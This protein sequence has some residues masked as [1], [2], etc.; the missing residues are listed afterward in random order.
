VSRARAALAAALLA[1]ALALP[2]RAQEPPPKPA[3]AAA[4]APATIPVAEVAVRVEELKPLLGEMEARTAPPAEVIAIQEGVA[5]EVEGVTA[6][7][8]ESLA[9][10]ADAPDLAW[11]EDLETGWRQAEKELVARDQ[12]LTRYLQ[13]I[14]AQLEQ[15]GALSDLWKNTNDVL[16]QAGAPAPILARVKEARAEI[17]ATRKRIEAQRDAALETQNQVAQLKVQS[18]EVLTRV[19]DARSRMLSTLLVR[20]Q[21]PLWSAWQ[22][23]EGEPPTAERLRAWFAQERA[24]VARWFQNRLPHL[25]TLLVLLAAVLAATL[26]L[27]RRALRWGEDDADLRQTA[28]IFERPVA[29]A[30][31]TWL[32]LTPVFHG[33]DPPIVRKLATLVLLVPLARALPPL[34]DGPVRTLFWIAMG[35]LVCDRARDLLSAA[36][37]LERAIF[38][39]ETAL[40]T[41]ALAW[42]GRPARLAQLALGER[43]RRWLGV[44]LRLALAALG[45]ALVANVLGYV[46]L[47]KLL[48]DGTLRSG[49]VLVTA[50]ALLR[51]LEGLI[52]LVLRLRPVRALRVVDHRR[53]RIASVALRGV[54]TALLVLWGV[55][56]LELFRLREPLFAAFGSLFGATLRVR[57]LEISLGGV[58]A[59][60]V[61]LAVSWGISRLLRA[62]LEEDVF[63]RFSTQRGVPYAVSTFVGYAVLTVGFL[64][65]L[66]AAGIDFGRVV[67]FA[68]ALGVG[69][70]L[71]LQDVVKNFVSGAILLFERP[72]QIG[73][74]VQLGDLL[75]VVQR[76]G[77]RSST[78]R[79]MDGAEVIIPNG[80]LVAEP[81]VNWTLSDRRRRITLPVGA[82]YGSDPERVIAILLEAAHAHPRVLAEP[83]PSAVFMGFGESACDFQLFAWTASFDDW[84]QT[85]S[86]L[87][88]A[89]GRALR[90]AG[91]EIPFPQREVHLRSAD[92]EAL[93][94]LARAARREG[95]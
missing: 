52:V 7:A 32:F 51:I 65:A 5:A 66:A 69:I 62:L 56:T 57:E 72:I 83:A 63:P 18:G 28:R 59:F 54:R 43:G 38:A 41:A 6:R 33:E 79:S 70:G 12:A 76:I 44:A 50:Y 75:G 60:G 53:G 49:Y 94:A 27:R 13:G 15:L 19:A 58:F 39:A 8:A 74:A 35:F 78:V 20:D 25:P 42:L 37:F 21:A 3:P 1:A 46:R 85:R 47:A 29:V 67:L 84:V 68:S 36:P 9:S 40:A 23:G 48:G 80:Q 16:V 14:E 45:A 10:L 77:L 26:A 30:F 11:L 17:R 2:A 64:L 82:A 88:M 31:I 93:A 34:L 95:G 91:I 22:T 71:G 90:E 24:I 87:A 4:P 55:T 73:D 89:V 92:P 61:A 86:E 81:I